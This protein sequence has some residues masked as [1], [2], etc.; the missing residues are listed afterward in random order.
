MKLLYPTSTELDL[1][2]LP[3]EV[4]AHPYEVDQNIPSE[5]EDA[6]VLVVWGNPPDML[7]DAAARL[8]R[9]QVDSVFSGR[10]GQGFGRRFWHRDHRYLGE[11]AAQPDRR[12]ARARAFGS[13]RRGAFTSCATRSAAARWPGELGGVQP[14][15]PTGDFRTLEDAKVTIWGFGS[16]AQTLAPFLAMLGAKVTGVARSEGERA[17]FPVRKEEDLGE[18]LPRTDALVMILPS[19]E[20]TK[21]ALDAERS[22]RNCPTTLGSSTS[23]AATRWTKR[24]SFA[25][26]KRATLRAQ[27]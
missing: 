8:P 20:A 2:A 5:H 23:G 26:C 24:R 11:R 10:T 25:P 6:E 3:E 13:W 7:R 1:S 15:K 14:V 9:P 16:I 18:F 22:W 17:G 19:T 27:R 4:E 21:H 12:G